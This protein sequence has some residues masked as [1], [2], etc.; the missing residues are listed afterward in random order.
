MLI[1][2]K[3]GNDFVVYRIEA[4]PH[5][6]RFCFVLFCFFILFFFNGQKNYLA[7]ITVLGTFPD[8]SNDSITFSASEEACS[9]CCKKRQ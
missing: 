3:L 8:F 1:G 9:S 2:A 5:Y 4:L 7:S 6:A